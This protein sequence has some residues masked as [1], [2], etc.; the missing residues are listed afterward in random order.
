MSKWTE[1][2]V[3]NIISN[4]TYCLKWRGAGP[5]ISEDLW[6][7]AATER[8]RQDQDRGAKFL[9]EM[10]AHLRRAEPDIFT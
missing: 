3:A 7:K 2:D 10:L 5:I 9:R 6:I 8:I 1:A 4:P